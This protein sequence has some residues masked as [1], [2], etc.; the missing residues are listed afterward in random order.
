MDIIKTIK[1]K[2]F[3]GENPIVT[4]PEENAEVK[5]EVTPIDYEP[6]YAT[7]CHPR[8]IL[9]AKG[10]ISGQ[11]P[12][13]FYEDYGDIRVKE[14]QAKINSYQTDPVRFLKGHQLSGCKTCGI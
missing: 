7:M 11:E 13:S 3:G 9:L 14:M 8:K 2:I 6:F 12:E 1:E 5:I 10:L 4:T